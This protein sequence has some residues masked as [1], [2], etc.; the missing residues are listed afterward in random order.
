MLDLRP[1]NLFDCTHF[2]NIMEVAV[3]KSEL[4]EAVAGAAGIER[5][6]ADA[7]VDAVLDTLVSE[8]RSGNKVSLFGFGTFQSKDRPARTARNPQTGAAVKVAASKA[9][10]FTPAQAFKTALNTRGGAKKA[11]GKKAAPAKSASKATK[12]PAKKASTAKKSTGAAKATK[13]AKKR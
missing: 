7:A 3:N 12:A 11:A 1:Q 5:R 6:Q 4:V 13:S 10:K 2:P 9:V 8:V